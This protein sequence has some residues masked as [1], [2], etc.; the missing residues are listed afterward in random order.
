MASYYWR[1]HTTGGAWSDTTLA[2]AN[3]GWTRSGATVTFAATVGTLA[4]NDR[5]LVSSSSDEVALP[6]GEY[7]VT[8]S[9]SNVSVTGV[10]DGDASG[11]ATTVSYLWYDAASGGAKYATKPGAS[12]T[13]VITSGTCTQT[14]NEACA[15]LNVDASQTLATAT[16]NLDVSGLTTIAGTHS[17]GVS[18]GTGLTTAGITI[19]SGGKCDWQTTSKINNSSTFTSP[20]EAWLTS[21][22]RGAYVQ[23]ASGTFTQPYNQSFYSFVISSG[24]LTTGANTT[25]LI[26]P[27]GSFFTMNS[28]TTLAIPVG[29]VIGGGTI[30]INSG[31]DITGAGTLTFYGITNYVNNVVGAFSLTGSAIIIANSSGSGFTFPA[32]DFSNANIVINGSTING[33]TRVISSGTL[34]CKAFSCVKSVTNNTY[35]ISNNTNSPSFVISGAVSV[36]SYCTWTKGT[37]TITLFDGTS[38]NID[39]NGASEKEDIIVNCTGITKTLTSDLSTESLTITA[40]TLDITTLALTSSGASSITGTLKIGTSAGT[41]FTSAGIT[42]NSG[43]RMDMQTGSKVNNSS[44]FTAPN[45]TWMTTLNTG[46]YRQTGSGSYNALYTW[47]RFYSAT[48]DEG[49]TFSPV[50]NSQITNWGSGGTT[51]INGIIAMPASG[52][53]VI[54]CNATGTVIFGVNSNITGSA[55]SL[56]FDTVDGCVLTNNRTTAFSFTGTVRNSYG[57]GYDVSSLIFPA[58]NFENA[59]YAKAIDTNTSTKYLSAGT[60]I[61]A[62][63]SAPA[64]GGG[65]T[66][67]NHSKYNPNIVC[68]GAISLEPGAGTLNYIKGTGTITIYDGTASNINFNSKSVENIVHNHVGVTKSYA[69]NV[70]SSLITF[71]AGSVNSSVS[72]TQ[73]TLAVSEI[74]TAGSLVTPSTLLLHN[75]MGSDAEITNSTVGNNLTAGTGTSYV[76]GK[77]GNCISIAS[78]DADNVG[79]II[80]INTV[81]MQEGCVEFWFNGNAKTTESGW[82]RFLFIP[83]DGYAHGF[84]VGHYSGDYRL[85]IWSSLF[86]STAG[87]YTWIFPSWDDCWNFWTV[88]SWNHYAVVFSDSAGA[89]NRIQLWKNGVRV[90]HTSVA[91][92]PSS[93]PTYNASP[94]A[95]GSDVS[96]IYGGALTGM[97]GKMDNVKAWNYARVSWP[98]RFVESS[99][100]PQLCTFKDLNMGSRRK[101]NAKSNCTNLGNNKGIVFNDSN[102]YAMKDF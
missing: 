42:L 90:M 59:T 35:T 16:Y 71:Q 58:W 72:G 47:S 88:G 84:A 63:I 54:G 65:T 28:S 9:G 48:I 53:F 86:L 91:T 75:K 24:T 61:A 34:K 21:N 102:A 20:N 73:R 12:D 14:G 98:D 25:Y 69:G 49:V 41:G 17:I 100:V 77:Y 70:T 85:Q 5:I 83:T 68:K 32:W 27:S 8:V 19:N 96:N 46:H 10:D 76:T 2:L 67:F 39:L 99:D 55:S 64:L 79:P 6:N 66:T 78:S 62:S 50:A 44:Y 33:G 92:E 30:T 18:A 94:I 36:D 37:G 1:A 38:V 93:I 87:A 95:I 60:L 15:V 11:T 23:T 22:N 26:G 43:S 82:C 56:V 80:P 81:T 13:V 29:V 40:G 101:I 45:E 3:T 74:S 57:S 89:G 51:T 31:C 97:A 7:V 4:T 52:V